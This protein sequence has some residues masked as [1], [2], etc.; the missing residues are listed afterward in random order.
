MKGYVLTR[1]AASDLDEIWDYLASESIDA[2][3]RV[4]SA[5]EKALRGIAQNPEIGHSRQELADRRHKFLLVYSYLIVYRPQTKPIQVVR[6][7]HASRD[8]QRLL[9]MPPS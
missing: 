9:R 8:A 5:I 6:I 2:A 3:D 7:L 1:L 4:L